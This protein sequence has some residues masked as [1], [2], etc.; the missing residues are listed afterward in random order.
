ML[1]VASAVVGEQHTI[2]EHVRA[3]VTH[4]QLRKQLT[5]LAF[6]R[7]CQKKDVTVF[8][9]PAFKEYWK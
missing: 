3:A 6:Y 8:R 4:K 1:A 2:V 7:K 9:A 5:K